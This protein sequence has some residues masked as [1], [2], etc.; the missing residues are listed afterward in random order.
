M[1]YLWLRSKHLIFPFAVFFLERQIYSLCWISQESSWVRL[2]WEVIFK[3]AKAYLWLEKIYYSFYLCIQ[4][5]KKKNVTMNFSFNRVLEMAKH[6]IEWWIYHHPLFWFKM[7]REEII[8]IKIAL[9]Y[10]SLWS[11]HISFW[12]RHSVCCPSVSEIRDQ[13]ARASP[14]TLY[15]GQILW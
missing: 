15:W 13:S 8:K 14:L 1:A 11:A 6:W 7:L 2:R 12:K 9:F 10:I 4:G 3:L 5:L